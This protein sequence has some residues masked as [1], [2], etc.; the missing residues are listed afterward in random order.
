MNRTLICFFALLLAGTSTL[1]A[2]AKLD[3]SGVTVRM[4]DKA[5]EFNL[6]GRLHMDSVHYDGDLAGKSSNSDLRRARLDLSVDLLDRL[7]LRGEYEFANQGKGWKNLWAAF[8]FNDHL[9]LRAGQQNVPFSM[10]TIAS[11]NNIPLMERSLLGSLAPNLQ[12]GV[13]LEWQGKTSTFTLGYFEN[14]L[15]QDPGDNLD[16]GRGV[17]GRLTHHGG[18]TRSRWHVGIATEFRDLDSGAT[19]RVRTNAGLALNS[20][21][22]ANTGRIAGIDNYLA[23]GVELALQKGAWNLQGQFMRRANRAPALG[24]PQYDA[25][26]VQAAWAVTG[27]T[28]S[29]SER[30]GVFTDI[31]PRRDFGALE[32]V[33]RVSQLDLNNATISGGLQRDLALGVNW[34]IGRNARVM[35]EH[36]WT[37]ATPNRNGVDEKL[38]TWGLRAQIDF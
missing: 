24:N 4:F 12:K 1:A 9:W 30:Q 18:A 14:G 15:S 11:S 23:V 3:A 8:R 38:N 37:R 13:N 20:P 32:L 2:D 21:I 5:L 31:R 27:E 35:A 28:R 10:E 29:Y 22:V 33:A 17:A 7:R 16:S 36:V 26:Y 19:S 25:A 6:G 34:M